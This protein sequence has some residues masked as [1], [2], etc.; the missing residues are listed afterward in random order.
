M[1]EREVDKLSSTSSSAAFVPFVPPSKLD[2]IPLE[3]GNC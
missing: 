2:E 3:K 1:L